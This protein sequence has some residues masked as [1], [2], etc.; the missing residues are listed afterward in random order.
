MAK[1]SPLKAVRDRLDLTQQ[2]IAYLLGVSVQTVWRWEHSQNE[3]QEPP[4]YIFDL[5]PILAAGKTPEWCK[6]T[7]AAGYST[8]F[9]AQHVLNCK[10]CKL[11]VTYL[12]GRTL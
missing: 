3:K 4:A 10:Q 6:E 8:T 12:E 5:L 2:K 7:A 9:L 1:I 11:V